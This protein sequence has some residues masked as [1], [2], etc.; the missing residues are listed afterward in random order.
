MKIKKQILF[1]NIKKH[2]SDIRYIK[3]RGKPVLG[4]NFDN[5]NE[6]YK[7]FIRCISKENGLG[8]VFIIKKI[9]III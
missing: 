6:K 2:I 8:M 3:I 9:I 7:N 5:I 4:I 1:I